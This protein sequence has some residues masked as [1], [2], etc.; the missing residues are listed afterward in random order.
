MGTSTRSCL[1]VGHW[2]GIQVYCQDVTCPALLPVLNGN[3]KPTACTGAEQEHGTICEITCDDGYDLEGPIFKQCS[4][5]G[6]WTSAEVKWSCTD[7]TAP[8]LECPDNITLQANTKNYMTAISTLRSPKV[9]DSSPILSVIQVPGQLVPMFPVGEHL[10]TFRVKDVWANEAQCSFYVQIVD[11]TRPVVES[12]VPPPPAVSTLLAKVNITEPEFSDNSVEQYV[13]RPS[14]QADLIISI[15]HTFSHSWRYGVTSVE[16]TASDLANNTASCAFNVTVLELKELC[17][18]AANLQVSRLS[19]EKTNDTWAECMIQC[20]KDQL[21]AYEM[22]SEPIICDKGQI[23]PQYI[24]EC[25][26]SLFPVYKLLLSGNT[27]IS[28]SC[29]EYSLVTSSVDVVGLQL[30]LHLQTLCSELLNCS[31]V[32]TQQ[33]CV[34]YRSGSAIILIYRVSIQLIDSDGGQEAQSFL[35]VDF[36]KNC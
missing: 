31:S 24:P 35:K 30:S 29:E 18:A 4:N 1:S 36:T 14:N 16:V 26:D 20:G 6:V 3:M 17:D 8:E 2:S 23:T 34:P 32:L 15:S 28:D 5:A 10:I 21:L 9:R 7:N 22:E 19:C 13:N 11:Q 33:S 27:S 25:S 12:C